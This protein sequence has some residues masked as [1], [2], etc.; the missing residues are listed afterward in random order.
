MDPESGLG[1]DH[2]DVIVI[3]TGLSE[4][5][6]AAGC[7]KHGL[8]VLHLD[9]N[10]YYGDR[11]ASLTVQEL[12]GWVESHDQRSSISDANARASVLPLKNSTASSNDSWYASFEFPASVEP[13]IPTSQ[14]TPSCKA[15]T[16]FQSE[17]P[18]LS[19]QY[20]LSLFPSVLP[21]RGPLIE[22]LIDEDVGKYVNFR[23]V[24]G[25]LV[26]NNGN[27]ND[28]A[29]DR[30]K[31]KDVATKDTKRYRKVPGSKDQIFKDGSLSL[32]EK[33]RLMKF[34]MEAAVMKEED[35]ETLNK[36]KDHGETNEVSAVAGGKT[37]LQVLEER[38]SL[39]LELAE[40]IAFAIAFA[41]NASGE[42]L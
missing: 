16:S 32:L 23:L 30:Q 35:T 31:G 27:S 18:R 15:S 4:S 2:F 17:L 26:Y 7:A 9:E 14:A 39:P 41:T 25:I 11:H 13:T 38:Y 33:R 34:L 37:L 40:N 12:I 3:G 8:S 20:A 19:R 21:S 10:E 22:T 42:S 28:W 6:V 36:G 1:Q 24:D 5:I 29:D